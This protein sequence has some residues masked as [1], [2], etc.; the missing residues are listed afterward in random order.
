MGANRVHGIQQA[1]DSDPAEGLGFKARVVAASEDASE[2]LARELE[3]ALNGWIQLE[4]GWRGGGV[5][6]I[7]D[8]TQVLFVDAAAPGYEHLL[9][10]LDRKPGQSVF[11]IVDEAANVPHALIEGLADDVL[12][13]PF[14]P[15]EVLGKLRQYQRLQAYQEALELNHSYAQLVER[16]RDDL[17]LA[18]RMQKMRLPRRFPE[19]K[20][21]KVTSRYLAGERSGGDYVDLAETRDGQFMAIVMTDASTYRLS[22][23]VLDTLSRR[24]GNLPAEE[25]RSCVTAARRIR[26]GVLGSMGDRDQVSLFYGV[27]SRKD[28]RLKFVNLGGARVF[29]AGP[30]KAFAEV[31]SGHGDPL[32]RAMSV[33][34]ETEGEL[35]LEPGGRLV[36]VSDGVVETA[37]GVAEVLKVLEERR[38]LDA[39]DSLNELVFRA[40]RLVTGPDDLPVQDC[41]AVVFDVDSRV[42]RLA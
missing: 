22:S 35:A 32:V 19:V 6:G 1:H 20:G 10:K 9:Q 8:G 15:L 17:K 5:T 4:I 16:L 11:L 40:K 37:G 38:A 7:E 13:R 33:R 29:Y 27:M 24:M 39:A 36:L 12:V 3:D 25:I 34:T 2:A 14:R 21:F 30:G 42:I 31:A 41:T 28:Y 18:E 26:D 23:A